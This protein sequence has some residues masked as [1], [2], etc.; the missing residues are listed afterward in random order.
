MITK[1]QGFKRIWKLLLT[2]LSQ[3]KSRI[4]KVKSSVWQDGESLMHP[5]Y[6][7]M[8]ASSSKMCF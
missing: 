8:S 3:I 2:L 7:A 5:K 4:I 1:S 6:V